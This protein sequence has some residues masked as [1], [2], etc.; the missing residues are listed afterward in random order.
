MEPNS[1]ALYRELHTL[2]VREFESTITP[3][4]HAQLASLL[5]NDS[6]ARR[7][8]IE[9]MQETACLRWLCL[10]EFGGGPDVTVATGATAARTSRQRWLRRSIGIVAAI[11]C[12]LLLAAWAMFGDRKSDGPEVASTAQ[13]AG[14][15]G[16]GAGATDRSLPHV[17]NSKD[18]IDS[19]AVATVTALDSARWIEAAEDGR[20]LARCRIG[21]RWQLEEGRAELTFDS[22][23][24][25]TLFAPADFDI[26]SPRSIRCRRGRVTALVDERGKGFTIETPQ[27]KVVDLGTQFGLNISDDGETQVVVFQGSVDLSYSSASASSEGGQIRRL[28]QGDALSLNSS[29]ELQRLMAVRRD[30]FLAAGRTSNRPF[31]IKDVRDN[32]R[33]NESVKSY[34]IVHGGLEE[35]MPCF[36]DRDH[37]WNSI[38][39]AGLPEFLRGADYIMPF[40]DDKFVES[41]ELVVRISRPAM[42]YVFFDNNM[43]VPAWLRD[44]FQDT[45]VEIGLDGATTEWHPGNSLAR[46]AGKSVDFTFSIWQREIERPGDIILGG[47]K[48]PQR[49]SR[50]FNMYGI[51]AVATE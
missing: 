40:N 24:L 28:E 32:I 34:Q 31:V 14:G 17:I 22:G 36:V 11:A 12:S 1:Q 16:D 6:T 13:P 21:E 33:K 48:P 41:L 10:E 8:Y 2:M 38:D 27:A 18:A 46:G 5:T 25:V 51:A 50:G 45:G 20:L 19:N 44:G 35:D 3:S 9:Y 42:L 23:V 26:I 39:V 43:E 29:G 7:L 15:Q 49:R 47:V 37:E 4:E 30:Q